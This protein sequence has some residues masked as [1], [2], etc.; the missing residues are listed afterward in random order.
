L[1]GSKKPRASGAFFV[2]QQRSTPPAT[3]ALSAGAAPLGER[4]SLTIAG[5]D[6]MLSRRAA[7]LRA[8]ESR[9]FVTTVWLRRPK[10]Q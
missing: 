9:A 3:A 4:M 6:N 7:G 8:A 1:A 5:A 2:Q 10:E